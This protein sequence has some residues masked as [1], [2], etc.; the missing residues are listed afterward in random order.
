MF[1]DRK[2]FRRE[3]IS[4]LSNPLPQSSYHKTPVK[5]V[6]RG[7]DLQLTSASVGLPSLCASWGSGAPSIDTATVY[8]HGVALGQGRF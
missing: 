4:D 8:F 3:N 1:K 2:C 6:D 5:E 7:D